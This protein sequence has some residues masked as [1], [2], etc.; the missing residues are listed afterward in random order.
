MWKK[1]VKHV[2]M[3]M[4]LFLSVQGAPPQD[5]PLNSGPSPISNPVRSDQ[6]ACP[7]DKPPE[8]RAGI[9]WSNWALVI[10]GAVTFLA[11]LYQSKK[12]AVAAEATQ[13]SAA[14]TEIAA[15]AAR[16]NALAVINAQRA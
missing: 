5:R 14:A 6:A 3:A 9:E 10:I 13:A 8:S 15:E 16:D 2:V 1:S 4:L 7:G 12:T 11:I